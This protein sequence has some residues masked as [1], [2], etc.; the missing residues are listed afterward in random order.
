MFAALSCVV[1]LALM[2]RTPTA[3]RATVSMAAR[4]D[5]MLLGET[6]APEVLQR[7]GIEGQR[8]CIAFFCRDD[9]FECGKQLRDLEERAQRY[10]DEFACEIV[11][12]RSR[13]SWV[14]VTF[15]FVWSCSLT[16]DRST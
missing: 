4:I 11:A 12:I 7:L 3:L 10:R 14:K 2:L 16:A 8:V 1:P 15:P 5:G 6:V 9:G 13:G